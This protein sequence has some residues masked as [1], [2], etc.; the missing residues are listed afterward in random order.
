MPILPT[1]TPLCDANL[2]RTFSIENQYFMISVNLLE[3]RV[4]SR[5]AFEINQLK[6][7]TLSTT[8]FCFSILRK[9]Y[10]YEIQHRGYR[11]Q[12]RKVQVIQS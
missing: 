11:S 7:V 10:S 2:D 8:D 1:T 4:F 9:L 12:L 3:E 5:A 6:R